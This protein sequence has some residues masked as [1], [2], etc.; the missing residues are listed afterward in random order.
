MIALM[1]MG[2]NDICYAAQ[3]S[4]ENEEIRFYP[5]YM[6]ITCTT[7]SI[8]L[9][10]VL[11]ASVMPAKA[12]IYRAKIKSNGKNGKFKKIGSCKKFINEYSDEPDRWTFVYKDHTVKLGTAY[13][14]KYKAYCKTKEEPY[15]Y[16]MCSSK[17]KKGMAAK[18]VGQYTCKVVKNTNTKLVVKLTGKSRKNGLLKSY[19][20]S[21][22]D[23]YNYAELRYKNEGGNE[24]YRDLTLLKY[25]YDGKKWY[26]KGDFSIKGKLS[27]YLHFKNR[28]SWP[29]A[30]TNIKVA[31]Y[32]Y[33]QMFFYPVK[34]NFYIS[35]RCYAPQI[36][37]NLSSG[38]ATVKDFISQE[39]Y[40]KF[41]VWD[42]DIFTRLDVSD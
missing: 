23:S 20:F 10:G 29:G 36:R 16:K 13:A 6:T 12:E 24:N 17:I 21:E 35:A 7:E 9:N 26:K 3:V 33:V 34:Y 32:Q 31:N 28:L 18:A 38:A 4:G 15:Q 14:Y 39:N 37:F 2:V 5:S 11:I 41:L 1:F 27:I 8:S 25:S 30:P 19:R 22:Y 42:G 40:D